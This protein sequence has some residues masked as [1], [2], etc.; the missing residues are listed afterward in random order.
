MKNI[1]ICGGEK[2]MREREEREREREREKERDDDVEYERFYGGG[3]EASHTPEVEERGALR[4]LP[5]R[6]AS[7]ENQGCCVPY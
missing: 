6:L 5:L 7:S 3:G 2:K 4:P 1:R